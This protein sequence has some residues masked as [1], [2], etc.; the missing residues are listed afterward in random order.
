MHINNSTYWAWRRACSNTW[1]RCSNWESVGSGS[2][3]PKVLRLLLL[4]PEGQYFRLYCSPPP[5][6]KLL[7]CYPPLF[8]FFSSSSASVFLSVGSFSPLWH[9]FPSPSSISGLFNSCFQR[10][11]LL[12]PRSTKLVVLLLGIFL[13]IWPLWRPS[14]FR[15]SPN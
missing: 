7:Y 3:A 9:F 10:P 11:Y 6:P 1:A 15:T 8:P 2:R 14:S 4:S 12:R 5:M 13:T